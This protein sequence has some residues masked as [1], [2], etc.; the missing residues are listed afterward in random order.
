MTHLFMRGSSL[1]CPLVL[2]DTGNPTFQEPQSLF[3]RHTLRLGYDFLWDPVRERS[4]H[5]FMAPLCA[6][7]FS[8]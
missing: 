6:V 1:S 7:Q 3:S 8:Y 4:F 2:L 5:N